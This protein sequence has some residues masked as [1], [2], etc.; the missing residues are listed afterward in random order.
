[1]KILSRNEFRIETCVRKTLNC[2]NHLKESELLNRKVKKI[3]IYSFLFSLSKMKKEHTHKLI[4]NLSTQHNCTP[5]PPKK[6]LGTYKTKSIDLR[7]HV[8]L[9]LNTMMKK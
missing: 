7:L 8:V 1:M 4:S 5:I 6:I 2:S 3:R 9:K